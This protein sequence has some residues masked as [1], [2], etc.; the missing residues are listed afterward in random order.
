MCAMN[1]YATIER[2]NPVIYEKDGSTIIML[3]E[4]SKK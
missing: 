4:K 3:S 1:Y 2:R